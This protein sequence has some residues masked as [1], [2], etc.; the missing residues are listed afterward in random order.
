MPLCY[1]LDPTIEYKVGPLD[2]LYQP[3]YGFGLILSS[4]AS[5]LSAFSDINNTS[6]I[7]VTEQFHI[8]ESVEEP[9]KFNVSSTYTGVELQGKLSQIDKNGIN[10]VINQYTEYYQRIYL[11]L[12]STEPVSY[13]TGQLIMANTDFICLYR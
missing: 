6:K 3:N 4:D 1:W 12:T 9:V 13:C 7:S 2:S 10:R 5:T 11:G 8:T